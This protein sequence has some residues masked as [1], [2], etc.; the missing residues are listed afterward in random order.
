MAWPD[1]LFVGIGLVGL[2]LVLDEARPR[3]RID[4]RESLRPCPMVGCKSNMIMDV[5]D[6]NI[7]LNSGM[8]EADRGEGANRIIDARTTN[9]E[10]HAVVDATLDWWAKQSARAR[11]LGTN[12]PESCLED[13][14]AKHLARIPDEDPITGMD[15]ED[16]GAAMFITRERARQIESTALQ[17]LRVASIRIRAALI[18]GEARRPLARIRRRPE[19]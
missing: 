11:R 1:T 2:M 18:S 15:L 13:V 12:P 10:F 19:R 3:R 16:V 4:C 5:V 8:L 17:L 7:I 9:E 6:G 14:I